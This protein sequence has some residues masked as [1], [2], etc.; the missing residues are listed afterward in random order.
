MKINPLIF[1]AYD[2]RG[3]YERDLNE[4]VF[5]KIGFV[6]GKKKKK[7]VVGNDIRKSGEKLARALIK[8]LMSGRSKVIYT[9]T[10]S[11]GETS[12]AGRKLKAFASLFITASHLPPEWNGLKFY[13]GNGVSFLEKDIMPI[14]DKVM[15]LDDREMKPIN[16][17]RF[18]KISVRKAYSNFILD[19][20]STIKNNKLKVVLDCKNG[21][22]SL[23]A[24]KIFKKIGFKVFQINC[25]PDPNFKNENPEPTYESTKELRRE[26]LKKKADLGVAFDG[27]G[28]RTVIIDDKIR[29]LSGNQIG[30]IIGKYILKNSKNKKIVMSVASSATAEEEFKKLGARVIRIPV[31]HSYLTFNCKKYNVCFGMEESGHIV[32]PQ[33]FWFDDALPVPLKIAEIILKEKKKLSELVNEI[34]IYP[35]EEIVFDCPDEVKFGVVENLAKEFKKEYKKVSTIDGVKVNFDDSWILIRA[36]NTSPKIRLY[37]E[38]K[39]ERKLK[40][41]KDKFSKILKLCIRQLS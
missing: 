38:A 23:V 2:V 17:I 29:Y 40:F 9:G 8:G 11:F 1:R 13:F 5:Q 39:N 37:I 4:E 28:D 3:I 25:S 26:V 7:F 34:K 16:R 33:Y 32:M 30:A 18:K 22:M 19:K 20:F 12:F 10:T 31:G 15:K 21:S 35:F 41:L 14:R 36:S 24:P 6:L 27:D